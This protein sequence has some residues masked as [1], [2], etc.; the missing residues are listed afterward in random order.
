MSAPDRPVQ[1]VE[2]S[3]KYMAWNVKGIEGYLKEIAMNL[4]ILN[5][6]LDSLLPKGSQTQP[7]PVQPT[8]SEE[9]PF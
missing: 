6:K 8:S 5:N 9:I 2:V 1:P 3:L 4:A 7:K